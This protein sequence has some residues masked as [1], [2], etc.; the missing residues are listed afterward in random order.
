LQLAWLFLGFGAGW[1]TRSRK[2]SCFSEIE[3]PL[4][5]FVKARLEFTEFDQL[6]CFLCDMRYPH[7][8]GCT[9]PEEEPLVAQEH[10]RGAFRISGKLRF[11][12]AY[13]MECAVIDALRTADPESVSTSLSFRPCLP[14]C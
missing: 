13:L 4:T 9:K 6:P 7:S 1:S 14:C 8:A 11:L 5:F 2:S 3:T 10:N 12:L